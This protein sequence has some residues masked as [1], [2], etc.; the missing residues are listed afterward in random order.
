MIRLAALLICVAGQANALSCRPHTVQ[1]AYQQAALATESYVVIHGTLSFDSAL[2]PATST[3][4][5]SIPE[6]ALIPA[7]IV[8]Q[9]LT[10]QGFQGQAATDLMFE[11]RCFATWCGNGQ[12]GAPYLA[13]IRQDAGGA[14]LET[15]PCGG[16]AFPK[17]SPADLRA[18]ETCHAGGDCTGFVQP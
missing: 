7:R 18:V 11:V 3:D 14:V 4:P 1:D 16:F 10:D 6:S 13:F 8:G 12:A 5:M 15:N 17:P 9:M 2:L